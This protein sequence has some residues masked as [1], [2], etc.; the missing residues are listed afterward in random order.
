MG[1]MWIASDMWRS[2]A[3][4]WARAVRSAVALGLTAGLAAGG[5]AGEV[6]AAATTPTL[7]LTTA[8][9]AAVGEARSVAFEGTFDFPNALEVG[10]PLALIIFQ[11]THFVRYPVTGPAHMGESSA[12]AGGQLDE[13]DVPTLDLEGVEA[14]VDVRIVTFVPDRLRVTLPAT[15]T[16]GRATAVLYASVPHGAVVS[17]PIVFVLP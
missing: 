6:R 15:F 3:S 10:Y 13:D 11:G 7:V 9:P 17:N 14:P 4:G 1:P 5:F 2:I 8:A 12:A 16:A